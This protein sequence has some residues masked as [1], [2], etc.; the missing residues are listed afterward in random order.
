MVLC[1]TDV[2]QSRP[3]KGSIY[4]IGRQRSN[5][6]DAK[7]VRELDGPRPEPQICDELIRCYC[8][9]VHPFLP[10]VNI[11]E[12]LQAYDRHQGEVSP[13]LLWSILFSAASVSKSLSVWNA[14][15][16]SVSGPGSHSGG[17]LFDAERLQGVLVQA[18]K[19]WIA[20]PTM[21]PTNFHRDST[22]LRLRLTR[23]SPYRLL[24]FSHTTTLIWKILTA[25][26]TGSG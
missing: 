3:F 4:L 8:Y 10:L 24:C 14:L 7:I 12:F 22:M 1:L 13:L 26:G 5:I 23:Q 9:Y 18:G 11:A 25:R 15:T 19:G 17:W 6:P 16:V 20:F 2:S 21:E